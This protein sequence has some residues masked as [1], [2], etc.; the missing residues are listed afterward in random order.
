MNTNG[1][2]K[3]IPNFKII[4]CF[5]L[6]FFYLFCVMLSI[7]KSVCSLKN[8]FI[9]LF[10]VDK[11]SMEKSRSWILYYCEQLHAHFS[12]FKTIIIGLYLIF[13]IFF[14]R[15]KVLSPKLTLCFFTWSGTWTKCGILCSLK[16]VWYNML[17]N[18]VNTLKNVPLSVC[19][20]L[21]VLQIKENVIKEPRW[22]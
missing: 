2:I 17:L 11:F 1:P 22:S 5:I 9:Y 16:K 21:Y 4:T 14:F 3:I 20:E 13:L 15:T 8:L 7:K 6:L 12:R 19:L 18:K 10:T